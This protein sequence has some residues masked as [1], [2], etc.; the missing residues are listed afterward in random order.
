MRQIVLGDAAENLI[1]G[2]LSK[3]LSTSPFISEF[4][5]SIE[6]SA[7]RILPEIYAAVRPEAIPISGD[8]AFTREAEMAI[9]EDITLNNQGIYGNAINSSN[10]HWWAF[11]TGGAA[12]IYPHRRSQG[13]KLRIS[14]HNSDNF[15]KSRGGIDQ[16]CFPTI[17]IRRQLSGFC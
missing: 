2:V 15:R 1:N 3:Q 5:E 14:Q 10:L 4:L 11:Y 9:R 17:T 8:F 13:L 7:E 16:L 6:Y 12:A